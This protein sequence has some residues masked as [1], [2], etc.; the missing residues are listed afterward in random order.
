MRILRRSLMLGLLGVAA[1]GPVSVTSA[2]AQTLT[3]GVRGGPESIDP[4]F[5]ATGTHAEALKHVFDTL[6]WSGRGLELE[7]RLAESWRAIDATTWEFKLRR[8]VKFHD[9]SDFTAED[10]KFSI[11]RIPMVSGPNPTTI[12]VRRV[13]ETKIIDSHTIHVVTDGPAP[14]LPNDFIRLFI[15][16]S[17]AA[18]GLTRENANEAFNSGRA[19]IGTGPYRYVSW[20]PRGE[21]VLARFDGY[22]GPKEPWER[23]IRR[24]IPNDAARVAQLRAGQLDLITRAPASDVATLRRDSRLTVQTVPTVYVFNLEMDVR[25]RANNI[26]AKDGS[27]LPA[28]PLRDLRVRQAIDLAIDR[29]TL[30]EVAMEG[31]GAPVNQMVTETIFG[32]NKALPP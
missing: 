32:F 15:V 27:A 10:V 26:T 13:K 31:L 22:W 20:Q 2:A 23:H 4:H 6:V 8:G 7:P 9:G 16:S 17:K 21:L 19:A 3:I 18:A 14:N 28:N 11:E 1:L 30:A 12:Y 5:T 24:E 25:E 29:K